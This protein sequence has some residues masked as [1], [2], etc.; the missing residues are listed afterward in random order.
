MQTGVVTPAVNGAVAL[1]RPARCE[2]PDRCLIAAGL[3]QEF[4]RW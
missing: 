2:V 1:P 4:F 3:L